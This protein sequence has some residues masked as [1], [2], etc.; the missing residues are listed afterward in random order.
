MGAVTTI[1]IGLAGAGLS[2]Y[3]ASQLEAANTEAN[4]AAAEEMK[5][6]KKQ[7]GVNVMDELSLNTEVFE[8]ELENNLQVSA[9]FIDAAQEGDARTLASSAGKIGA[10]QTEQAERARLAQMEQLNKIEA[11][12]LAEQGD[13]NQQLLA[14]DAAQM[15]DKA[16]RDA[17]TRQAV[18]AANASGVAALGSALTSVSA[19]SSLTKLSKEDKALKKLYGKNKLMLD[20]QN[21]S[22]SDFYKNP[23][24]LED[25]SFQAKGVEKFGS[26]TAFYEQQENN[27]GSLNDP[28]GNMEPNY[29]NYLDSPGGMTADVLKKSTATN[30]QPGA[31]GVLPQNEFNRTTS[32]Y[33]PPSMFDIQTPNQRGFMNANPENIFA[34][35]GLSLSDY[36]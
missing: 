12:Q 27:P 22:E 15:Q 34:K 3:Q 29:E 24:M 30:Y 16:G 11:L 31:F 5:R 20:A 6:L 33:G 9:D 17:Q 32:L 35:Y 23:N 21:I 4:R 18:A 19:N 8:K 10:I 26:L 25:L 13:I 14:M 36:K 2:F 28:I 1:A 7:A